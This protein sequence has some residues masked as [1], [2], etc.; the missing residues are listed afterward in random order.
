[1][2]G[3]LTLQRSLGLTPDGQTPQHCQVEEARA[4]NF[5]VAILVERRFSGLRV[6]GVFLFFAFTIASG[7][8]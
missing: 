1:M 7:W 6:I 8:D 5:F 2:S 3:R 4:F